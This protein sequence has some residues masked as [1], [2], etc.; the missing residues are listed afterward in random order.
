MSE[1]LLEALS[2]L[3]GMERALIFNR[4]IEERDYK[5]LEEIY[6]LPAATLRK[7][8]ERARKKLAKQLIEI[9]NSNEGSLI[10]HEI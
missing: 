8:Y 1:E 6:H 5:E 10:I 3:S 4:I 9:Q 2:K 7:R